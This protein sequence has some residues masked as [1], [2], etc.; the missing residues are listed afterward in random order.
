MKTAIS[1]PDTLFRAAESLAGRLGVSRSRL[2]AAA[3][4][5]YI[6]R[7]QAR[8]VSERLDAV[9]SSEPSIIDPAVARAQ[10]Q[11]LRSDGGDW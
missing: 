6:A 10:A 7:H 11:S 2:Y 4:E 9:Y 5:E 3:L 8:R 1:L